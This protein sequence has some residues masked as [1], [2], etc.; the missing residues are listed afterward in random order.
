MRSPV[1]VWL[2]HIFLEIKREKA[3]RHHELLLIERRR[4]KLDEWKRQIDRVKYE[5]DVREA[6][7]L[8]VEPFLPVARRLQ[9]MK[10]GLEEAIPWLET[11]VE[12]AE[13]EKIDQKTAAYH[14]A[15]E[16]RFYRQ[17]AGIQK[18][19]EQARQQLSVLDM[20]T[21]HK[22]QALSI[23][24]NLQLAGFS[25]KDINELIGLITTWN[26]SGVG[27]GFSQGNGNGGSSNTKLDNKLMSLTDVFNP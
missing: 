3:Q 26:K 17:L 14:V 19:I 9:D 8:E 18:A 22:Q 10:I 21:T 11:I 5:L 27:L 4:Q 2:G 24:I 20:F 7:C 1:L 6:R 12:K 25:E 13:A 15:S 23:L 16:L